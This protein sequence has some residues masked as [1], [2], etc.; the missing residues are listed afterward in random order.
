MTQDQKIIRTKVELLELAKQLGNAS[1]RASWW[2]QVW[3]WT[4]PA[5]SVEPAIDG[6]RQ[7]LEA[8]GL[9]QSVRS[10]VGGLMPQIQV[11]WSAFFR[12]ERSRNG[13]LGFC[14]FMPRSA[15]WCRFV[16][17]ASKALQRGHANWVER[18][19]GQT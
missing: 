15:D 5:G 13:L 11:V 6:G 2:L 17:E 3:I 18:M 1:Q 8:R 12:P 19:S 10:P 16:V 9:A 4:T 7:H 14:R